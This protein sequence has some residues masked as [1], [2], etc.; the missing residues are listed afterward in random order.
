MTTV[1]VTRA[2][3]RQEY[4]VPVEGMNVLAANGGTR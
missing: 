1:A 4:S 2:S 3:T